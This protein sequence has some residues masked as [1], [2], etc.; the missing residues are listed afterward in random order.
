MK[1]CGQM[2]RIALVYFDAGGGHRS[3]ATSICDAI[4]RDDPHSRPE[5]VNLQELLDPLDFVLRF[6][7][8]RVQDV[9]NQMIRNEWTLGSPQLMRV[10]QLVVRLYH[11]PTV[12][13]LT[14]YFRGNSFDM[15]V[16]FVPHFNRALCEGFG[17]ACP[18]RP[19]VTVLT[20]FADYPPH[21]WIERQ[22]QFLVCGTEKA[23]EQAR[24]FGHRDENIFRTSGMVLKRR[25]YDLEGIDRRRERQRLGLDAE[26]VTGIVLFGGQGARGAMLKIDRKLAV[27]GLPIQL[28]FICG[29]NDHLR[30]ELQNQ[31]SDLPRFI[32]GFTTQVPYYMQLADF[33]IGKPGPGSVAEALAMRL[34]VIVERNAWTLPQE[35]YNAVWIT[36]HQTGIVVHNFNEI[37]GAVSAL[38]QDLPRYRENSAA[39]ENH[40]L[41][42]VVD[43]LKSI[44]A[45]TGD[46][47]GLR[48]HSVN[49][50]N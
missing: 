45:R 13:L 24:R 44:L 33:F 21:F 39:T 34:P 5:L 10:L 50:S 12:K 6:T 14:K 3:T 37:A 41:F 22:Q 18:G 40:A 47:A 48:T 15:V 1:R 26:R 17:A 43:I 23:V 9:Y 8:L 20:D 29:K 49:A 25:F 46:A 28:I 38:L 2:A 16:S 11:R 19:F 36:E 31:K 30:E 27:S 35:R 42:E 32:E 4:Q 7:G